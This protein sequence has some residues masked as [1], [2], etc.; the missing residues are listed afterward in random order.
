MLYQSDLHFIKYSL[1]RHPNTTCDQSLLQPEKVFSRK[2]TIKK[3]NKKLKTT[4]SL[5]QLL[6]RYA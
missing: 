4:S 1:V 2:M 5:N 6:H 3:K